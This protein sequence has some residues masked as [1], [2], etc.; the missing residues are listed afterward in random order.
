MKNYTKVKSGKN[1]WKF[2]LSN[3]AKA[4]KAIADL[5]SKY[6]KK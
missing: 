2:I 6:I 4:V 1:F 3:D 5:K